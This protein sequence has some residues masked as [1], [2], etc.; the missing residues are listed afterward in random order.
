MSRGF[1]SP[2]TRIRV[3]RLVTY[4]CH[5]TK[6]READVVAYI[7][8]G[9]V[10]WAVDFRRYG[11]ESDRGSVNPSGLLVVS[12]IFREYAV[13]LLVYHGIDRG[14]AIEFATNL[15]GSGDES[16]QVIDDGN[17]ILFEQR[18]KLILLAWIGACRASAN[19]CGGQHHRGANQSVCKAGGAGTHGRISISSVSSARYLIQPE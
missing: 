3:L 15:M 17:L 4:P 10:A 14:A 11:D 8:I 2:T 5:W 13:H 19:N 16:R 7:R 6:D 9:K 1:S 18:H 12:R